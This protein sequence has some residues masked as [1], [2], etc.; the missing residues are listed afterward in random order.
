MAAGGVPLQPIL[1]LFPVTT[2]VSCLLCIAPLH[3]PSPPSQYPKEYVK[4]TRQW[5][6][7]A[8]FSVNR[9]SWSLIGVM[10]PRR[11][12]YTG[13]ENNTVLFLTKSKTS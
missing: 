10:D 5:H 4:S 3:S 7:L 12:T 8:L 1:S 11:H 9:Y 13:K 2:S 6:Q